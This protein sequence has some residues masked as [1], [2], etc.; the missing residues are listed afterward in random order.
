MKIWFPF[1]RGKRLLS[2]IRFPFP[3]GKGLGVRLLAQA[4]PVKKL[5]D[6]FANE[7]IGD[8]YSPNTI[9]AQANTPISP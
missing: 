8:Q 6:R 3:L 7:I 1:P 2:I 9:V 4:G 5:N